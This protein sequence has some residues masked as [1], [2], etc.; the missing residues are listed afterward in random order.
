[1][2]QNENNS[3]SIHAKLISRLKSKQLT[4]LPP[5]LI[6]KQKISNFDENRWID[7]IV[8]TNAN[9]STPQHE[10]TQP[11]NKYK[12]R[13]A[14]SLYSLHSLPKSQSELQL[15]IKTDK[16]LSPKR[17]NQYN[18]WFIPPNK[19]F[20]D[21]QAETQE[22]IQE[23]YIQEQYRQKQ[24]QYNN[25]IRQS[26]HLTQFIRDFQKQHKRSPTFIHQA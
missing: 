6:P 26:K 2:N 20:T 18:K 22:Y 4:I 13:R 17:P 24:S 9:E 8:H 5:V 23:Q 15:K 11:D 16:R 1:M 25:M 21:L 12:H 7:K 19:R 14:S 10:T 3:E